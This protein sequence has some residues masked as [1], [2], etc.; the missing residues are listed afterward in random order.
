MKL[1]LFKKHLSVFILIFM[2]SGKVFSQSPAIVSFPDNTENAVTVCNDPSLVI[3]QIDFNSE[4]NG[5]TEAIII[6]QLG[7]A[8][9]YVS[10]SVSKISGESRLTIDDYGGTV[11]AP[12]FKIS[13]TIATNNRLTF[14]LKQ[15]A[16]CNTMTASKNNTI[17][18]TVVTTTVNEEF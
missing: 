3:V 2:L 10:G 11:N 13:G 7:Q 12:Q 18:E 8:L 6:L 17:F 1:T 14:S 9:E 15:R 16:D 5:Q 4:A